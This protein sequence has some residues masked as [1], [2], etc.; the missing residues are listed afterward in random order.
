MKS[1]IQT[2]FLAG[3][4]A[5]TLDIL[6]PILIYATILQK[7]TAMKI[8]QSIASG[9]F[10]KEAYSGGWQMALYGLGF[11]FMIATLFASFYFILFRYIP[12]LRINK[13]IS[14]LLYGIFVWIVMNIIVLPFV[15]PN[16]PSKNLDFQLVLSM[17]IL[18]CCVGLPIALITQKQ[19]SLNK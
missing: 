12:F 5:G 16:M 3:L 19:Y 15:F 18:M 4:V 9:V 2:I 6:T 17:V 7:T 11:H 13:I 1:K 8:L 10:K 14:G